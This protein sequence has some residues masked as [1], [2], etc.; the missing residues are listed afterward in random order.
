MLVMFAIMAVALILFVGLALDAGNI[1]IARSVLSKAADAAVITAVQN[2]FKGQPG[3]ISAAQAAFA[4]NYRGGGADV[5]PPAVSFWVDAENN[6][7]VSVDAIANIST[8]FIRLLPR[9]RT[10]TVRSYAEAL[11]AKLIMGLALDRSGSMRNNGG[12]VA[13]PPA[14]TTFINFFDDNFD[15]VAMASFASHA[16]TDVTIRQ[17]FKSII[18]S[19]I[20]SMVFNGATFADGGLKLAY[21]QIQSV[22]V[23]PGEKVFK[24]A[25]F[26]TDGL[27]NTCQLTFRCN[28]SSPPSCKT[29]CTFNL[30][31]FDAGN[32]YA[33]IDP[34]TGSILPTSSSYFTGP[35]PSYCP[36]FSTFL[37]MD[38]TNK[39]V[40]GTNF[41]LEGRNSALA[42]ANAMRAAGIT[43]YSVGLGNSIDRTFLKKIANTTD[44]SGFNPN[45][46]I[47]EAV[48]APSS[49]DLQRVFQTIA[50]NILLRLVQ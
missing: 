14:V 41:R 40:N 50:A 46:P 38:G 35:K 31:G 19:K 27:A 34:S 12:S 20:N 3:A 32:Y 6:T 4:A 42:T 48:F 33:I 43:V 26:F 16:T 2:M 13:L 24:A 23:A 39:T 29:N 44:A 5:Q 17:P 45:Q 28:T 25:V 36:L 49:E 9:F 11:R 8:H 30:G 18:I 15:K 21:Q 1:Y 7:H 10:F 47:G 22:S 37:S